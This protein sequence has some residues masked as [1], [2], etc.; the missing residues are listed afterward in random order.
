M[1]VVHR[2]THRQNIYTHKIKSINP[3][4]KRK[5]GDMPITKKVKW[6]SPPHPK[7]SKTVRRKKPGTG[8]GQSLVGSELA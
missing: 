8:W 2:Y 6:L 7:T 3:Q 1:Y 4:R 5:Q